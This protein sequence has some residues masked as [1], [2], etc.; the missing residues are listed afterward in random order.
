MFHSYFGSVHQVCLRDWIWS[1]IVRKSVQIQKDWRCIFLHLSQTCLRLLHQ[2]VC[3]CV[4]AV[5][6]KSFHEPSL[7][8]LRGWQSSFVIAPDVCS[9]YQFE[10]PGLNKFLVVF[11]T[12]GSN[13][14]NL[15]GQ[16][17]SWHQLVLW[18][19][20]TVSTGVRLTSVLSLLQIR[21]ALQTLHGHAEHP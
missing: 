6:W 19:R 9:R 7:F 20:S 16:V 18:F 1:A 15:V 3:A 11:D 21:P 2:C 17:Q 4:C 5:W 14:L 8:V 12:L 10:I 13:Y